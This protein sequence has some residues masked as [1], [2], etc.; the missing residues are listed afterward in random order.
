MTKRNK[1]IILYVMVISLI[2]INPV[3]AQIVNGD[4][5]S[6]LFGW[7]YTSEDISVVNYE[8]SNRLKINGSTA[9]DYI[10]LTQTVD[11]T[12]YD[13][14]EGYGKQF[15]IDLI[16]VI[17][18]QM[19]G[20]AVD[21]IDLQYPSNTWNYDTCDVSPYSGN[22]IIEINIKRRSGTDIYLDNI[23]LIANNSTINFFPVQTNITP[24]HINFLISAKDEDTEYG[25]FIYR[26]VSNTSTYI[27][28][29]GWMYDEIGT[30]PIEVMEY[31][32]N[33]TYYAILRG[34][35]VGDITTCER[36]YIYNGSE[37]DPFPTADPTPNITALPTYTPQPTPTGYP[38]QSLI[39]N[40]LNSSWAN[41]WFNLV[42][43]TISGFFEPVYNFWGWILHPINLLHDILADF[44]GQMSIFFNETS[45]KIVIATGILNTIFLY[46][47][48][49][50][51]NLIGYYLLWLCIILVFKGD[52]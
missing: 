36:E 39:N 1:N 42:E 29:V 10:I 13:I 25:L 50:I 21:N 17:V 5:E 8:G 32:E 4:F 40:S 20:F 28:Y 27:D 3:N 18:R 47:P 34:V 30:V 49:K 12:N 2:F 41:N 6:G 43:N 22:H 15:G 9:C 31:G 37:I 45:N 7:T 46:I 16:R 38:N 35:H 33:C 44:S 26:N 51:V 24:T 14:F 23:N 52:T 11:I 19:G 48:D